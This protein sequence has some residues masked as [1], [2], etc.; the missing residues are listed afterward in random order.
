MQSKSGTSARAVEKYKV[1]L[2]KFSF[3]FW[4]D[5]YISHRST[6]T[7]IPDGED[8]D[9]ITDESDEEFDMDDEEEEDEEGEVE[10]YAEEEERKMEDESQTPDLSITAS[11]TAS[12]T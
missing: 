5:P 12:Q 9:A 4:L 11:A 2:E 7:N 3:M 10:E 6:K 8:S 1:D